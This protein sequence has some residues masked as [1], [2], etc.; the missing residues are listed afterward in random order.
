ME[1]KYLNLELTEDEVLIIY[2]A[3]NTYEDGILDGNSTEE[4][5]KAVTDIREI[6]ESRL[7]YEEGN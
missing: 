6:I 7:S 2:D 3:L 5:K 4:Y 1:P